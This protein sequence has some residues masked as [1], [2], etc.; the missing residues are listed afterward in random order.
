V[1]NN[2]EIV[3]SAQS[4]PIAAQATKDYI[5]LSLSSNYTVIEEQRFLSGMCRATLYRTSYHLAL[6]DG[7]VSDETV[8]YDYGF[9]A[10]RTIE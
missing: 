4:I 2:K 7:A 1:N 3:F 6:Q 8:K 10:T 9:C 5:M